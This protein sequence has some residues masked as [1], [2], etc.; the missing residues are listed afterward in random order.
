MTFK[1]Q[2]KIV[3]FFN[4]FVAF[5]KHRIGGNNKGS[6]SGGSCGTFGVMSSFFTT[7][8]SW[9]SD[10]YVMVRVMSSF[11]STLES[12]RVMSS[13]LS[14]HESI[15]IMSSFFGWDRKPRFCGSL[16]VVIPCLD[17]LRSLTRSKGQTIF[18]ISVKM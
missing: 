16:H 9:Y 3:V 1:L 2:Y 11:L 15:R 18:S 17:H 5:W 10:I 12:I 14:T 6:R 13:N 7:F 8:M 4:Y